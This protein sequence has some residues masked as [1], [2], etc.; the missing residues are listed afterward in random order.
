MNMYSSSSETNSSNTFY[1]LELWLWINMLKSSIP[2]SYKRIYTW[3]KK[4]RLDLLKAAFYFGNF[5]ER[6]DAIRVLALHPSIDLKDIFLKAMSSRFYAIAKIGMQKSMNYELSIAEK[7][8]LENTM[9]YWADR[10]KKEKDRINYDIST[11]NDPIGK[12]RFKQKMKY[13]KRLALLGGRGS[14]IPNV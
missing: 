5:R 11:N 6:Y 3:E 4:N 1:K 8:L 12:T 2:V 13:Y 9:L 14:M 7:A 10:W